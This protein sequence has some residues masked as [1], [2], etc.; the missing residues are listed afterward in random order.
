M[1][2]GPN[3]LELRDVPEAVVNELKAG[4]E[5]GRWAT[6]EA[7]RSWLQR[8]RGIERPY[9]TVWLAKKIRRGAAGAAAQTPRK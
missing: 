8:E 4:V 3:G 5:S 6:A 7:A 1:K 9:V 2:L